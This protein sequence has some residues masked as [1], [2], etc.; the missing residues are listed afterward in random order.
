ML[1]GRARRSRLGG[2]QH[3]PRFVPLIDVITG[4]ASERKAKEFVAVWRIIRLPWLYHVFME[5]RPPHFATRRAW[6]S[7]VAGT[8]S[9]SEIQ[10]TNETSLARINF[11]E[12]LGLTKVLSIK[13]E[14][15]S[16]LKEEI[17]GPV[18]NMITIHMIREA[19]CELADLNFLYDMFEIEYRRTCDPLEQIC[20]RMSPIAGSSNLTVPVPVPRSRLPDR[21]AWLIAVRNFML[22]WPGTKPTAFHTKI[23]DHPTLGDIVSLESAVAEV[24]CS[25][26]TL[27]LR[28]RPVLPRYL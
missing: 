4:V 14:S 13:R 23:P 1:Q 19:V 18:D 20:A 16:F 28:R 5:G 10:P 7:F 3:Q 22:P 17:P 8:F 11:A 15:Y 26:V 6:K 25:N 21:V 24:Y 12:F 27:V 2:N 9:T